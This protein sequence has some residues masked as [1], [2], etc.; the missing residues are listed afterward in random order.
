M[1]KMSKATNLILLGLLLLT[2]LAAHTI[3]NSEYLFGWLVH[4]WYRPLFF[5][6][7]PFF[8]LVITR[9]RNLATL[10]ALGS[11]CGLFL[12]NYL[13][14]F[15][16]QRNIAKITADMGAEQ[17]HRLHHHPGVEIWLGTLMVFVIIGV[18]LTYRTRKRS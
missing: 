6:F 16:R 2:I 14:E 18:A 10:W 8:I 4:R 13:G 3:L 12:G 17:I 7:A 11:I 1:G 5:V 9:K 15:I